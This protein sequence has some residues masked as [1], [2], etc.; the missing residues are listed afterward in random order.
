MPIYNCHM[1]IFTIDHVPEKFLP[2]GM[3][4]LMKL[5]WIRRPLT[6]S[7]AVINPFSSRDFFHRY[8]NFV[9]LSYKKNQ[10]NV[11]KIVRSYYPLDTKFV[12]LPMDMAHMGAGVVPRNIVEQHDELAKLR[13]LYPEQIIP[14]A[15]IDPRRPQVLEMLKDLVENKYFKGIKIYPPLGYMPGDEKLDDIYSYAQ[16]KNIPVMTHCSRGGIRHK[17]LQKKDTIKFA[18]PDNYKRIMEKYKNLRFCMGHFGGGQDWEKY[19]LEPWDESSNEESRSWLSKILDMIR[20]GKF[21]NLYADISYTI[22]HFL[23][24][25]M[26]LKVL[27]EDERVRDKVLFGSDFYMVEQEKFQERKLSI[28]LRGVIGEDL[29]K[30]ISE[31]NPKRYL[32]V[33]D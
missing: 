23:E 10:E 2:F 27:L 16:D 12:V 4:S 8:S 17:K 9:K 3:A 18:D 30:R 31:I 15:A 1:H 28:L 32:G 29:F 14:F 5:K 22:F 21:P 6:F 26:I 11:F 33:K 7:L 19:L 24:N 20:S 25:T 13:E